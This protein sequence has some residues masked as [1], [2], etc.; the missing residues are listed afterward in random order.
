MLTPDF[1]FS[2]SKLELRVTGSQRGQRSF[3]MIQLLTCIALLTGCG[4][5]EDD[6]IPMQFVQDENIRADV[7]EMVDEIDIEH[8]EQAFNSLPGFDYT[9]Y[10][11]TEQFNEANFMVA[12]RERT[13]RHEGP[14][15][16]RQFTAIAADSSGDF[17]FGF[18]R[19]FVSANVEDEDPDDMSRYLFPED[20]SYLTERNYEAYLYHFLPD[21]L[22]KETAARVVEI[23]AK[24]VQGDGKNIRR[25]LYFFD[26]A[27]EQLIAFQLE[28]IDLALFFR[29]ESIFYT[30]IQQMADGSW[31]P[32]NTRFETRILMPF[33]P[34]Q[35]F[36][37][38]S[39]YTDFGLGR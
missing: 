3:W 21:T 5:T 24:P 9:R 20:P 11:R 23:R 8:F 4:G 19:R 7:L 22:M 34:Q 1:N 37:T 28:R 14:T 12:F 2:V 17:D 31:V 15:D 27:S 30:H 13:M 36:R 25:A 38:V 26:K 6:S 18:F 16:R 32:Y 10:T 29:E 33:K 39:T 35:R